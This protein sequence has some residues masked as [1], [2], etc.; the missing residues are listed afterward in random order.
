MN[1]VTE[2]AAEKGSET[3]MIVIAINVKDVKLLT[4]LKIIQTMILYASSAI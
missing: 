2:S 3:A 4:I 1:T